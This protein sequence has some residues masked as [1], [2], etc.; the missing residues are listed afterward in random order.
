MITFVQTV[1]T[2]IYSIYIVQ[3]WYSKWLYVYIKIYSAISLI[4][5]TDIP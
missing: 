5:C 3:V 2:G 1:D 4:I